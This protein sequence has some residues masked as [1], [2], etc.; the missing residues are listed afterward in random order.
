MKPAPRL[1]T[2]S[3]LIAALLAILSLAGLLFPSAIYPSADLRRAFLANDV[4]NLLI[5]LPVL[6]A[7]LLSAKRGG[8]FGQLFWSG[9]L[10]Y[11]IYNAVA[12]AVALFPS[13]IFMPH[14]A[15]F[16][17]SLAALAGVFTSLDLPALQR[18]LAGRVPERLSAGVLVGLG[19]LFFLRSVGQVAG[20]AAPLSPEFA[21]AVADLLV[22]PAWIIGGILL[23]RRRAAGYALG[24]GLLFQASLLFVG[25]LVFFLLQPL[26]LAEPFP[27]LDFLVIFVMGLVCFIPFGLFVRGMLRSG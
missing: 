14:A 19:S 6:A 24:A 26:L 9:A 27:A 16:I 10:L 4:V 12:Y 25:L 2:L 7:S 17:L 15:L 5:G 8:W 20:G 22:T 13:W 11:V 23:W 21:V 18:G 3:W 1:F